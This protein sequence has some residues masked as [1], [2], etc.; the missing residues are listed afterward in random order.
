MAGA[1]AGTIVAVKILVEQQQVPPV[2]VV[3]ESRH[4]AVNRAPA[5]PVASE[6]SNQAV[7]YLL[8]YFVERHLVPRT[9]GALDGE[10]VPVIQVIVEQ[11]PDYQQIYGEPHRAPPIGITAEHGG[12]GLGWQVP[13][14]ELLAVHGED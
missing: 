11:S 13:H 2:R 5:R 3:L 1:Q 10:V 14:P 4:T 9:G 7:G 12:V 8:G 6:S